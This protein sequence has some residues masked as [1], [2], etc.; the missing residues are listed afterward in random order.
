MCVYGSTQTQTQRHSHTC[1]CVRTHKTPFLKSS[2][3]DKFWSKRVNRDGTL[4]EQ[5]FVRVIPLILRSPCE[6]VGRPRPQPCSKVVGEGTYRPLFTPG[7]LPTIGVTKRSFITKILKIGHKVD[8][9]SRDSGSLV[10]GF[11]TRVLYPRGI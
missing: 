6:R 4:E 1:T 9:G 3:E 5:I 2:S 11:D 10:Y 8:I 7:C